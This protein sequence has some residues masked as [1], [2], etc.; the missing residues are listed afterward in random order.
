MMVFKEAAVYIMVLTTLLGEIPVWQVIQVSNSVGCTS[1]RS[2]VRF[3]TFIAFLYI[4]GVYITDAQSVKKISGDVPTYFDSSLTGFSAI[5]TNRQTAIGVRQA[6]KYKIFFAS[7]N[8]NYADMG[9]WFD[10]DK[11]SASNNPIAGQISG[12][13]VGG[14]ASL[15][16]AN[17]DGNY[18]WV[19]ANV[20]RV[21]KFG[22]G[23]SDWGQSITVT[24]ITKADLFEDIFG[25][26]SP[27]MQKQAQNAWLLV[28]VIGSENQQHV[29]F[30]GTITID[31][32]QTIVQ[33]SLE[34]IDVPPLSGGQWGIDQWGSMKWGGSIGNSNLVALKIPWQGTSKGQMLQ[35]GINETSS[36]PW[37][38]I[39]L[40]EYVDAQLPNI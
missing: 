8:N 1:P 40:L 24:F 5:I 28:E 12:M 33:S 22:L 20:D 35:V 13:N 11:Q 30:S 17:D 16:G 3:D 29:A 36:V 4:D 21:G 7:S 32:S 15:R 23:F 19:D 14:A 34:A 27:I 18:V 2:I 31:L 37:V 38:A 10:F 26:A 9:I 39:G 25:P 6:N